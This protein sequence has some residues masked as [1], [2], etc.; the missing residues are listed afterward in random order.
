VYNDEKVESFFYM[1]AWACVS[2]D[3]N[4][5]RV[6]KTILESLTSKNCE[7]KDLNW[8]QNKL[9]EN[10]KGKKFLVILD[11]LWNESYHD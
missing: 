9:K 3:F 1:K 7:G 5:V 8:L 2:E 11:D 6:T 10:L 4:A